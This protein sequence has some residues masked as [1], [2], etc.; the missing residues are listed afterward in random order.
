MELER[1]GHHV[2]AAGEDRADLVDVG[3]P[4]GVDHAVRLERQ[5]GGRVLRRRHPDGV[6]PEQDARVDPVLVVGIH[7]H[8]GQFEPGP[9]IEHGGEHF[10]ADGTGSI[11]RGAVPSDSR[12][13]FG[14]C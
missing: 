8:P 11:E 5:D 13:R 2:L 10:L 14:G 6:A 12:L 9:R 7:L 1:R 4:R 3:E